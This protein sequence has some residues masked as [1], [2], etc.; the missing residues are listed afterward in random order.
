LQVTYLPVRELR[1]CP[2]IL[3]R[4]DR[5]SLEFH[6]LRESIATVGLLQP[7]LVRNE[8]EVVDGL[9]RLIILK[10][11]KA[12]TAPCLLRDLTDSEVL[13]VQIA[14]N[15]VRC[16]TAMVDLAKRL[17]RIVH[18]DKVGVNQLAHELSRSPHWV[19]NVLNLNRLCPEAKAALE[20][21]EL[22][23]EKAIDLAKLPTKLQVSALNESL[24]TV[25]GRVR[26]FRSEETEKR[27]ADKY[28]GINPAFRQYKE[29]C[30]EANNLT[31]AGPVLI[32]TSAVTPLDGWR[33][34]I[35]WTLQLDPLSLRKR[36]RKL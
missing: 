14:A 3:R 22:S 9:H 7:L 24:E 25:R 28:G 5:T 4:V 27:L 17:W 20:R 6:Q 21:N 33:E 35:K 12:D 34:A 29:V 10:E 36:K 16:P 31:H 8:K 15:E 23:L 18:E 13:R 11:Q 1:P 26:R 19:K 30:D 32:T 2:L